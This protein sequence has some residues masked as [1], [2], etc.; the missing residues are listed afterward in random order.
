MTSP[1]GRLL[2][3]FCHE[4]IESQQAVGSSGPAWFVVNLD[5][6]YLFDVCALLKSLDYFCIHTV[7]H[8]QSGIIA[9]FEHDLVLSRTL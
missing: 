8:G 9:R 3:E 1:A 6:A 4:V 5:Q 2:W 7:H